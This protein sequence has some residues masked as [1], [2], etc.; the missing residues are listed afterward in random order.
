MMVEFYKYLE[1]GEVTTEALRLA[2]LDYLKNT[3]VAQLQHPFYWAGFVHYG[4]TIHL[5]FGSS[6]KT[7]W[8]L[9]IGVFVLLG[10]IF[11]FFQYKQV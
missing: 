10:F 1:G 9:A 7:T 2:K 5:D 4:K 11:A 6:Q 8:L 3:E